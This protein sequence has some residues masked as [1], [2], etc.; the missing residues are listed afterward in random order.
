MKKSILIFSAL[1]IAF[2]LTAFG[3]M[4]WT[5]PTPVKEKISDIKTVDKIVNTTTDLDLFYNVAPRFF[6]T[7]TKEELHNAKS[8]IDILPK[9]ATKAKS[10]YHNTRVTILNEH[11]EVTEIG[12]SE[13]LNIDQIKLLQS[14]DYSTNIRIQSDCKNKDRVNGKLYDYDLVYYM[15][16][17]PENEAVFTSGHDALIKY[18]K[19]N[20]KETTGMIQKDFLKP[21]KVNFTVTKTGK[22]ANV[23]LTSTSGY[24]SVDRALI[25]LI[26]NMPENWKPATNSKGEPVDQELIF[27][28]GLEGC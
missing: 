4:N 13:L 14:T 12:Q 2:S 17:V 20:S 9:K 3:Y 26:Y 11:N 23:K 1:L 19:E 22:I 6:A 8:I 15:T 28:F 16:I 21:G 7:V 25:D 24:F 27:F 5:N 10:A 18:L